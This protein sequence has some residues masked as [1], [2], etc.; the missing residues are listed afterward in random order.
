MP[1]ATNHVSTNQPAG[2]DNLFYFFCCFNPLRPLSSYRPSPTTSRALDPSSCT[3]CNIENVKSSGQCPGDDSLPSFNYLPKELRLQVWKSALPDPR[4]I[5]VQ[6]LL[7]SG[8][9]PNLIWDQGHNGMTPQEPT[10]FTSASPN[11]LLMP[12]F[13]ACKESY[14]IVTK[15]YS[16][17]FPASST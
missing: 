1:V 5:Y 9:D 8:N 4:I 10:H 12:F 11:D 3:H 17:I 15:E 2:Y 16:I 13:L 7:T 6:R 14:S